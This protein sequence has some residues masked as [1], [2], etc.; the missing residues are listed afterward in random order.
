MEFDVAI[1]FHTE[2]HKI[3]PNLRSIL[4]IYTVSIDNKI[5]SPSCN[6]NNWIVID[7]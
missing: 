3:D 4:Y 6:K 7:F 1:S 5:K 2:A